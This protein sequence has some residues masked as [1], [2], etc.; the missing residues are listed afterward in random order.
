MTIKLEL[1][2]NHP[3]L[4]PPLAKLL[5]NSLG[6]WTPAD[7]TQVEGW[8]HE[9]LNHTIP[10]A[11]IALDDKTPIGI[12]SLQMNDGLDSELKPWLADLCVDIKYQKRGVGE[13]LIYTIQNKAKDL[14]FSKLYL[15][16]PDATIPN[17][18]TSL[19]WSTKG[20]GYYHGHKVT[21][22]EFTLDDFN[23]RVAPQI[24]SSDA[25]KSRNYSTL[26]YMHINKQNKTILPF[27][28][29]INRTPKL[30]NQPVEQRILKFSHRPTTRSINITN[31]M[32]KLLKF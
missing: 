28:L 4:I 27:P 19:G 20:M 8:L 5:H 15:M 14:G 1:L 22:M 24:K 11:Y 13:L 3:H 30:V 26:A 7:L 17:Y 25:F 18:Y 9:W 2:K 10:L 6:K 16:A 12:C 29:L 32:R 31:I 21:I 23:K